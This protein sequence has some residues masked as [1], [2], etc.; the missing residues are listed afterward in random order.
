MVWTTSSESFFDEHVA[1]AASVVVVVVVGAI[2]VKR[3]ASSA[4]EL[5]FLLR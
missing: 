3:V 1:A 4:Y 5:G 2:D